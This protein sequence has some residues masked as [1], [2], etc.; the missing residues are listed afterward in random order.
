MVEI[1]FLIQFTVNIFCITKLNQHYSIDHLLHISDFQDEGLSVGVSDYGRV[2]PAGHGHGYGH[3]HG[4]GHGEEDGYPPI[5]SLCLSPS[6][7]SVT[8]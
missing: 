5:L 1:S 4:H 7:A 6:L 2:G 3:G 8:R